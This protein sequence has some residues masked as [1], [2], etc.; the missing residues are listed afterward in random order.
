MQL[1]PWGRL[2]SWDRLLDLG[3][4]LVLGRRQA[5]LGSGL[6][7]DECIN[8][9]SLAS[10]YLVQACQLPLGTPCSGAL[11]LKLLSL[12]GE[13]ANGGMLRC[14]YLAEGDVGCIEIVKLPLETRDGAGAMSP[15]I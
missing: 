3:R 10:N 6:S 15:W 7:L 2:W 13:L 1:T 9:L 5:W 8:D 11:L 14:S 4:L 12:I